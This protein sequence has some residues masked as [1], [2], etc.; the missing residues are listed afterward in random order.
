MSEKPISKSAITKYAFFLGW[1]GMHKFKVGNKKAGWLRVAITVV[2]TILPL[3]PG[4]LI[5]IVISVIEGFK[6]RKLS[7]A[8]FNRI[9]VVEQKSW[10]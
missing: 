9:Y 4:A 7:D 3:V 5:M 2:G 8:D 10:F 1:I 6:Y